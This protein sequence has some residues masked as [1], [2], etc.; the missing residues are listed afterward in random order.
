VVC[1]Y[2]SWSYYDGVKP[3]DL[4]A[5]LC[6]HLNYAF[7]T[8]WEDGNLKVEDDELDIKDGLF[9]RVTSLKKKNPKLKVL[10]SVGGADSGSIFKKIA[11]DSAKRG[12]FVGS[13]T[14]FLSEYNFDGLDVDWEYPEE[15]DR[16]N[17]IT[18]LKE[19]KQA[20]DPHG[21]LLTSAVSSDVEDHGYNIADMVKYLD[22]INL[23]TYDF[24]GPWSQYT[25]Q[26]SALYAASVESSW[27]K[28]HLNLAAAA[29]NWVK[30]GVPKNKLTVGTGFYGHSFTLANSNNHGLHAAISGPGK[31]GGEASYQ[32]I[33]SKYSGWTRVW[34]DQQKNPYK[35]S[36]N[37]W[38]GYDDK[39]SIWAKA[40]WIK[41]NK[42]LGVMIWS[43]DED[44]V[45]GRCGEK[46]VLLKQINRALAA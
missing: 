33:C 36:G 1:Y 3:E 29:N 21:W 22:F 39:D 18:L 26:N 37:Q 6:T 12:A 14:Y 15:A 40:A 23:M 41:D 30:A 20:F 8:I 24:Y 31:D 35:Y 43:I 38:I 19:L 32:T 45:D 9:K 42:F 4:D 28:D 5:N 46:Q 11:K 27:E 34:D 16:A 7:I 25:G 17:Y 10:L 44:D 2:S 13:S